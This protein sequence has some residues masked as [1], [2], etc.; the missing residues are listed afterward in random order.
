VVTI[1]PGNVIGVAVDFTGITHG[2]Y[3][4]VIILLAFTVIPNF[5]EITVYARGFIFLF[6]IIKT[7]STTCTM[8][9]TLVDF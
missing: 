2:Q 6:H 5:T 9:D 3:L 7:L 8:P 1:L 4:F